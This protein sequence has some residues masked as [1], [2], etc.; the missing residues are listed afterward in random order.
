MIYIFFLVC[1]FVGFYYIEVGIVISFSRVFV[2]RIIFFSVVFL[3]VMEVICYD[4]DEI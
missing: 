3:G 4:M 1:I 2:K